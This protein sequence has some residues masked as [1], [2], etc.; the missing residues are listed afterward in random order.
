MI[1]KVRRREG[2]SRIPGEQSRR[3]KAASANPRDVPWILAGTGHTQE[4]Y[5]NPAGF[6]QRTCAFFDRYLK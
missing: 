4:Y 2:D 5:A 1:N 3:L 6:M